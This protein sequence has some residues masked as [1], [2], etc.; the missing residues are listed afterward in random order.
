MDEAEGD[1]EH[2]KSDMWV[3]GTLPILLL[4]GRRCHKY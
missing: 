4:I 1:L 3:L 2:A